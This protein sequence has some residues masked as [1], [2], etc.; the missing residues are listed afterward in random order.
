MVK[1]WTMDLTIE[2][3]GQPDFGPVWPNLMIETTSY[4]IIYLS[5]CI[6]SVAVE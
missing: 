6:K 1:H 4:A 2:T 5:N 3:L